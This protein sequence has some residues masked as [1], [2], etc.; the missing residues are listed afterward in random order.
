M[1]ADDPGTPSLATD[2]FELLAEKVDRAVAEVR[3]LPED[4]RRR[5]LALKS[6]V[7]EVHKVGLTRIVRALRADPRGK[8]ILFEVVDDPA[9]RMLFGMHGLIRADLWTR[10]ER[11]VEMVRPQIQS[12]GGDV[13]LVAVEDGVAHV[14]LSGSCT[15]CSMSAVTLRT[16]VEEALKGQCPE[17]TEVRH[18]PEEPGAEP[19]H[20]HEHAAPVALIQLGRPDRPGNLGASGWFPGPALDDLSDQRAF[21]LDTPTAKVVLVR[22][23]GGVRAFRNACAHQG[24]PLDGGM[25][26]ADAGTITCPWHGFRFDCDSG[27]CLT[28][29]AA[30]LEQFPVRVENGVVWV[31]PE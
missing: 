13:A 20:A 9:V 19:D 29:P 11:V 26:D 17:I 2:D 21:A 15:G 7:E 6:A 4:A 23:K 25:V 27:E 28:A 3:G 16:T 31:R 1:A 8:E 10:A 18:V 5:A 24:L 14:R 30:Q 12:H 22:A